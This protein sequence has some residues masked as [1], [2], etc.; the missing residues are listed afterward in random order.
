MTKYHLLPIKLAK[1]LRCLKCLDS[2]AD[3]YL[4]DAFVPSSTAADFLG[5]HMDTIRDY[6]SHTPLQLGMA[7]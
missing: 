7:I 4:L 2:V 5:G 3:C 1:I 6:I